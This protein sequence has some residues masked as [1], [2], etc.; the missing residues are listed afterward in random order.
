METEHAAMT[1]DLDRQT[2]PGRK[3]ANPATA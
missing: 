1:T 2:V 3:R